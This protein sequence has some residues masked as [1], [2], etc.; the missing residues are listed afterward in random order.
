M[1][2]TTFKLS[3]GLTT[4]CL[5]GSPTSKNRA[6]NSSKKHNEENSP[7][8]PNQSNSDSNDLNRNNLIIV[9]RFFEKNQTEQRVN[10][11][12]TSREIQELSLW[13]I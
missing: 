12:R 8:S 4:T 9:C 2:V 10:H 5:L 7:L 3:K 11:R 13:R 6:W 1:N